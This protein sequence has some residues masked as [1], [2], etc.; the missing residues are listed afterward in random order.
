MTNGLG[1]NLG[2]P[3]CWISGGT[4]QGHHPPAGGDT[5]VSSLILPDRVQSSEESS[6]GQGKGSKKDNKKQPKKNKKESSKKLKKDKKDKKKKDED[7][8]DGD[9]DDHD[10]FPGDDD[11]N[12]DGFDDLDG[13]ADLFG[14][15]DESGGGSGGPA[16][17]P[18]ASKTAPR[19]RPA[20][21]KHGD[22]EL[23]EVPKAWGSH[24]VTMYAIHCW[25]SILYL[26]VFQLL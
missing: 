23:D 14:G 17:R 13:L 25:V 22:L 9:D 16:K 7:E 10:A 12:D 8:T 3:T 21:K 18:A 5:A 15:D 19:K 26:P 20:G 6:P 4:P 24:G 1:S 11:D 2:S